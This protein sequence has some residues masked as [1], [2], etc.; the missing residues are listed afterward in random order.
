MDQADP[1]IMNLDAEAGHGFEHSLAQTGNAL[2]QRANDLA[3]FLTVVHGNE[4]IHALGMERIGLYE[5]LDA[6]PIG[7]VGC[8]RPELLSGPGQQHHPLGELAVRR[9]GHRNLFLKRVS[10]PTGRDGL[11][12]SAISQRQWSATIE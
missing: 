8:H 10:Y 12:G 3:G 11:S 6:V 2:E 4:I 9:N 7:V 1:A 5:E